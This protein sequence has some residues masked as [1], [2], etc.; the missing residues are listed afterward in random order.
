MAFEALAANWATVSWRSHR[1]LLPPC[2]LCF[3]F[4]WDSSGSYLDLALQQRGTPDPN[5]RDAAPSGAFSFHTETPGRVTARST[6]HT[7]EAMAWQTQTQSQ[8]RDRADGKT[9]T[10]SQVDWRRGADEKGV[11]SELAMTSS[12]SDRRGA[13]VNVLTWWPVGGTA[14]PQKWK[15]RT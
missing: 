14:N 3:R 7:A 12:H 8:G 10:G 9:W 5:L 13:F 1:Q 2:T 4:T 15:G 6:A 11:K